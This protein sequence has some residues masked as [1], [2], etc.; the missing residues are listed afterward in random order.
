MYIWPFSRSLGAGSATTRNT[1]GLTR[2]VIALIVPPLPAPSRPSNT[3]HTLSPWCTTHCCR[4]TSSP[5]SRASSLSYSLRFSLPSIPRLPLVERHLQAE[6]DARAPEGLAQAR[7]VDHGEG[8]RVE[9]REPEL[10]AVGAQLRV[11]LREHLE[12]GVLDVRDV[13]A[14]EHHHR[15]MLGVDQRVHPFAHARRVGE[16]HAAFG[17]QDEQ[18]RP[19]LV[20]RGQWPESRAAAL[21]AEDVHRRVV[22]LVGERHERGDDRHQDAAQ[23][24]EEY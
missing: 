5:C 12:R 13:A 23:R 19:R 20:R 17:A 9:R 22:S 7:A 8:L 14:I 24:A 15:G 4:R 6:K 18:A 2:S 3:T 10:D 21:A 1:R 16:E 11:G